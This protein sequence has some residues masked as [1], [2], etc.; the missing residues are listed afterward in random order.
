MKRHIWILIIILCGCGEDK[1]R[2]ISQ[3]EISEPFID[4]ELSERAD[5]MKKLALIDDSYTL[6][7][8]LRMIGKPNYNQNIHTKE[9]E[10]EIKGRVIKYYFFRQ[11]KGL[12]NEVSDKSVS[13]YFD[14]SGRL[15][16]VKKQN[17]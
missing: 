11:T 17:L 12:V 10:S 1:N 13:L 6:E 15:L 3:S 16:K 9:F 2:V 4:V 7:R 8:V 14:T 5:F